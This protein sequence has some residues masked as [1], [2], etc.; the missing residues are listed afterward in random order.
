PELGDS[1]RNELRSELA[2]HRGIDPGEVLREPRRLPERGVKPRE[3]R[4]RAPCD[5]EVGAALE[6]RKR[7][8]RARQVLEQHD[9]G[10]AIF[11]PPR[12]ERTG[13]AY[14]H[15]ACDLAIDA[16]FSRPHA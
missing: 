11:G 14:R 15:L 6:L 12:P 1:H 16:G 7:A 5:R 2:V 3:A 8:P 10:A 13:Y 9:V 4:D